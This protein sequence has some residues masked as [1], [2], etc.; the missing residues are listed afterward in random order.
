MTTGETR[1]DMLFN[2]QMTDPAHAL[3]ETDAASL[4]RR[5]LD[6]WALPADA[7][8][9]LINK[10]ENLTYL[11]ETEGVKAVLR[12]HRPGYHSREAIESELAW[13]AD[14]NRTGGVSAPI[15]L[16][17]RDGRAVQKVD[18][19]H[20]VLFHFIEGTHP[21]END[22][23]IVPFRMLGRIA[24]KTHRHSIDWTRPAAFTRLVWDA[25]AVFGPT[26]IWA[27]WRDGPNV[28]RA[29]AAVLTRAEV[30]IKARL[31]AYGKGAACYG[32]IH[33]DMR[34]ANI[35][36]HQGQPRIIDFD[37]CGFGW[38]IYDFAAA[39]SFIEIHPQIPALKASWL[40][41]YREVRALPAA[42]EAEIDTMVM[43][44]RLA[45]LGWIGSRI[46]ATEPQALAPHFA[47]GTAA[48]AEDW[49]S[50]QDRRATP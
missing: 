3:T 13:A 17:G 35:L 45:L 36:L 20:L 49:L 41:G 18:G 42:D 25:D 4:A 48:L 5:A 40:A 6:Y 37:D 14:L 8:L 47:A 10:A 38:F 43:L 27:N 9:R 44:R 23:L 32:L 16:T 22:D 31:A 7:T 29:E 1:G 26:P 15:P 11:V 21:D 34:L 46:E 33:A 12:L 30:T 2:A 24:A 39:V 28:G 50:R 19:V